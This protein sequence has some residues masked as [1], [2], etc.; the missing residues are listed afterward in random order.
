MGAFNK[1]FSIVLVAGLAACGTDTD[2]VSASGDSNQGAGSAHPDVSL[3][4]TGQQINAPQSPLSIALT[5]APIDNAASV[6]ITVNAVELLARDQ[7]TSLLIELEQ[8]QS[9][10]LLQLQGINAQDLLAEVSVPAVVYKEVR[11]IIDDADMSNYIE[12]LDGAVHDLTVPSGSS[13]GLKLKGEFEVLENRSARFTIDFD[14]RQSIVRAGASSNYLLNPVLRLIDNSQAGHIRGTVD[15]DLLVDESC[16]DANVDTHN[17][18]YLYQGFNVELVDINV[19]SD[20]GPV[21][22]AN[23]RYDADSSSYTYEL[24]Y[25]T[26][27]E[28]TVALTCNADQDDVEQDD[29]ILFF[30]VQNVTVQVSDILFI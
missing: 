25:L 23:I 27:G 13:S 9:I 14:V 28:Y 12:L 5:D 3:V 4:V 18:V 10:D 8:P 6:V 24:G 30:G 16:S 1:I 11:L 20:L 19:E 7:E 21:T 29:D 22:T 17:A 26:A 15:A 2:P